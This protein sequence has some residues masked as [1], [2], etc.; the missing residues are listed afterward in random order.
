MLRHGNGTN[1]RRNK[2]KKMIK[3]IDTEKEDKT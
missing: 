1:K 2:M 3:F